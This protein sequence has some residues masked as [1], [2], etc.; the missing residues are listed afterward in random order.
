MMMKYIHKILLFTALALPLSSIAQTLEITKAFKMNEFSTVLTTYKNEFGDKIK[1]GVKDNAF[2][3]AVIEI[4]LEGDEHAVTTAKAKLSLDMGAQ[5][6]V[7]GVTKAYDNKIVF[8]VSSS[9]RTIYMICGDGCAKQTVIEGMQL[10][11]DR[12]Y[13]GTVRYTP[14]IAPVVPTTQAPKRQFF[15]FNVTPSNAIVSVIE[16]GEKKRWQLTDGVASNP[17]NHGSY[18]YS[19]SAQRYYTEEGVFVVSDT[20]REKT[21]SLKPKFGWLTINGSSDLLGAHVYATNTITGD[22]L[23][24]GVVPITAKDID[25]GQYNLLIQKE[26]YKD[27]TSVIT[28]AENQ[29]NSLKPSLVPNFAQLTLTTLEGADIIIDEQRIGTGTWT[30]TLELGEYTVE[31]RKAS[32]KS[33]YT[34]VVVTAQ[35]SEKSIALNAPVPIYGSLMV[36]GTPAGTSIYVDGQLKGKSPIIVNDLL[37]GSH[38]VRLEKEG[39]DKQE[40]TIQITESQEGNIEYKLNKMISSDNGTMSSSST[41]SKGTNATT[42]L[43]NYSTSPE[44]Y[45][46]SD[47]GSKKFVISTSESDYQIVSIP[48]WCTLVSKDKDQFEIKY[49]S[50]IKNE[51]RSG[52]I[53]VKAGNAMVSIRLSQFAAIGRTTS[54]SSTSPSYGNSSSTSSASTSSKTPSTAP[55]RGVHRGHEYVDLGLSVKWATCNIGANKPSDYGGYYRY[56]E[57]KPKSQSSGKYNGP[58]GDDV[59]RSLWGTGWRLPTAEEVH[60]LAEECTWTRTS[61]NGVSGYKVTGT[62]GNSIFIPLAGYMQE[63]SH[64]VTYRGEQGFYWTSTRNYK[65][66]QGWHTLKIYQSGP[67]KNC[68]QWGNAE[69]GSFALPIRPVCP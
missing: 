38:K 54:Q 4:E 43:V 57:T 53:Q 36:Q 16:N 56:G 26:K 44:Y 67:G 21:V 63:S 52:K 14:A 60:E 29:T 9:V 30:G 13:Y 19:V 10:K 27:Y 22:E 2:P 49:N 18:S 32:H 17:L 50:N 5:Y 35:T 24:L 15:S 42:L 47:A 48:W 39:Y 65:G 11:P 69:Y 46:M 62:N 3:Y 45:L 20:D 40:Q 8:L 1:Q 25:A 41:S 12:I 7:Q 6:M 31:S 34:K 64:N 58:I 37:I 23:Y 28:I 68:Y 59:A 55:T 61:Q 51:E 33:A 66:G